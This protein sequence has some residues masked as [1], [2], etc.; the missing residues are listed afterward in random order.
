[1]GAMWSNSS[2]KPSWPCGLSMQWYSHESPAPRSASQIDIELEGYNQLLVESA[3]LVDDLRTRHGRPGELQAAL[4]GASAMPMDMH[5]GLVT[6]PDASADSRA[7]KVEMTLAADGGGDVGVEERLTGWPATEWRD[8]LEVLEPDRVR[9]QFEQR[10][11]AAFFPGG[12][13]KKLSWVMM[14]G[15]GAAEGFVTPKA[16]A[17][18][19]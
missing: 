18:R 12:T 6:L 4:R 14:I 10:S 1:M 5:G 8:A 19:E 15:I 2:R 7:L 13:L 16:L 9:A 11:V 3:G 17:R